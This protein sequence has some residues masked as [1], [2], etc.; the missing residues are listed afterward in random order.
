MSTRSAGWRCR[1]CRGSG[2]T[3]V[4]DLGSQPTASEFPRAADP[5]PD[6][7]WQ[8]R[9]VR[10]T[11]CGLLQLEEGLVTETELMAI[12]PEAMVEQGQ[13][14]V[15]DLAEAGMAVP[16]ETFASF[17]SPHGNGWVQHLAAAGL[18][19]AGD[20]PA[21]LV[22][23]VFGLM[24][25]ADQAAAFAERIQLLAPGGRLVLQIHPF[26]VDIAA[27]AWNALRH[28][29]YAYYSVEWIEQALHARGMRMIAGWQYPLQG[30]TLVVVASRESDCPG[31]PAADVVGHL[32]E[33]ERRV[34]PARD[35]DLAALAEGVDSSLEELHAYV[36]SCARQGKTVAGYGAGSGV[37]ALLTLAGITS[38]D[39]V[40]VADASSDKQG[41]ALPV[42]RVPVISPSE[43]EA[44]APDRVLMFVGG[45]LAEV[46]SSMPG[47]ESHGGRWVAL[48]PGLV[49][50]E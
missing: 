9:M 11:G 12:E 14:A 50:V 32:L 38:A 26:G 30:G 43:L 18:V 19:P 44:L 21:D 17:E 48:A 27:G 28:G 34:A 39:L 3:L 10:C 25:E 36:E 22:V 47:I 46:R 35:T 5:L 33:W 42:S 2:G 20:S 4:L 24:H 37:P 49:E 6:N 40:A 45:L 8:L 15:R 23:D 29:H 16:G 41:R 7:V 31:S 13:L 1:W